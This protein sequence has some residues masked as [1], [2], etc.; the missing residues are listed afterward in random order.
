MTESTVIYKHRQ[1]GFVIIFTALAALLVSAV[2]LYMHYSQFELI[3]ILTV[4]ALCLAFFHS[5]TVEITDGVIKTS[6]GIGLINKSININSIKGCRVVTNS[7]YYGW[8]IRFIPGG[9]MFN[10][11]GLSAVEL[12]LDNNRVF[13]IGTDDS[14]NLAST[15]E[16]IIKT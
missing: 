15:I 12:I 4:I 16:S 14:K 9:I 3:V 8:G 7:L 6:M 2:S 10:V 1:T 5:Q 11:S 13:R